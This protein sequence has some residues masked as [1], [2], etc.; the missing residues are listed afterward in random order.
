MTVFLGPVLVLWITRRGGS[1]TAGRPGAVLHAHES[2][3]DYALPRRV[4]TPRSTCRSRR[5]RRT[6]RRLATATTCRRCGP[7]PTR[8]AWRP[9]RRADGAVGPRCRASG[10]ART[11]RSRQR[12]ELEGGARDVVNGAGRSTRRRPGH[13]THRASSTGATSSTGT[14]ADGHK[15]DGRTPTEG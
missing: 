14:R 3:I 1:A 13:L 6:P 15:Y 9:P 8:K 11:S 4:R 7:R 12:A 5:R 10:S 2:G